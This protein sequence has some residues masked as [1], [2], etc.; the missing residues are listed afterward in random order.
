MLQSV[1]SPT[2]SPIMNTWHIN[3]INNKTNHTTE[4]LSAERANL[5]LAVE[6]CAGKAISLLE[7]N[8]QDE[9]LYLLFEW[10]PARSTLTVV[11]TD[12]SKQKDAPHCV[13][14]VFSELETRISQLHQPAR[15]E[16]THADSEL[17]KFW[18]FDYLTTCT[19]FFK[20]SLVAIFH[21]SSRDNSELL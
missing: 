15:I 3:T 18:L 16:Q 8:I 12:A 7:D 14:G 4:F 21:S 6:A 17:I 19:A 11:L 20:F 9:S 1:K 13:I 2:K 10:G 5:K